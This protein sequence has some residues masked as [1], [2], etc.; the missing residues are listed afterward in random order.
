MQLL[1][2]E[3]W[4]DKNPLLAAMYGEHIHRY[5]MIEL[6]LYIPV[7]ILELMVSATDEEEDGLVGRIF[8]MTNFRDVLPLINEP[9]VNSH[10]ISYLT[11]R[12]TRDGESFEVSQILKCTHVT[13][14]EGEAATVFSCANGED[15]SCLPRLNSDAVIVKKKVLY[16]YE[17]GRV[18][19]H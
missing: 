11:P 5:Q 3:R 6:G 19:G 10:K 4:E 18:S 9:W 2:D 7:F 14:S 17:D 1:A 12:Y 16:S 8:Y 15:Y 13:T